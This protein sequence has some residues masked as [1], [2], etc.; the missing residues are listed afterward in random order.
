MT[1]ARAIEY[2]ITRQILRRREGCEEPATPLIAERV[3]TA[4]ATTVLLL[5]L[6]SVAQEL[7]WGLLGGATVLTLGMRSP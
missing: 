5:V 3:I 4:A 2:R 7:L 6:G 1:T